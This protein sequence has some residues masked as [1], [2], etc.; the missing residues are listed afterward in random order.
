MKSEYDR[1]KNDYNNNLT[2][3]EAY[4]NKV[5]FK[6]ENTGETRLTFEEERYIEKQID[7]K[8]CRIP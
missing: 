2:T 1:L 3:L 4:T 7:G 8:W 5:T 6:I